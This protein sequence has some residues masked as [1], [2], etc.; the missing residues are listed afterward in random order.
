MWAPAQTTP[1][2]ITPTLRDFEEDSEPAMSSSQV[3]RGN[4]CGR[5]DLNPHAF[6]RHPL[7]MVCLPVPPLPQSLAGKAAA[8]GLRKPLTE[9]EGSAEPEPA[10]SLEPEPVAWPEPEPSASGPALRGPEQ[11]SPAQEPPPEHSAEFLR[12]PA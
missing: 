6:R 12:G 1:P 3:I 2:Y 10:G 8:S 9:P 4:W 5:G 11:G 7:K